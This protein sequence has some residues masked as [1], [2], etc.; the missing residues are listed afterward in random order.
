MDSDSSPLLDPASLF[1]TEQYQQGGSLFYAASGAGGWAGGEG[2]SEDEREGGQE[3]ARRHRG[4]G[5]AALQLCGR[6]SACTGPKRPARPSS[7]TSGSLISASPLS[8]RCPP[9]PRLT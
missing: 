8:S 2:G 6:G 4:A 9:G 1:D 7:D 3:G 5:R